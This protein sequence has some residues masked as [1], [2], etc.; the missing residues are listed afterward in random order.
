[1]SGARAD[2][3]RRLGVVV[4]A[5]V[6]CGAYLLGSLP[7]LDRRGVTAEEVQPTLKRYPRVLEWRGAAVVPMPPYEPG[8]PPDPR[9]VAT[10]QWPVVGWN[11]ASRVWPVLVRGH[12]SA[13]GAYPA[14]VLGDVL[15]GGLVGLRRTSAVLGLVMLLALFFAAV[16]LGAGPVG[17]AAAVGV[18]GAS[19]GFLFMSRSGFGFEVASRLGMMVAVALAARSEPPGV[20]RALAIGIVA[21][22]AIA[23]RA[24]IVA[25]LVPALAALLL[26]APRRLGFRTGAVL[27]ASAVA[28][29]LGLLAFVV[30]VTGIRQ[31]AAPL[32]GFPFAEIAVRI[33][34]APRQALL[35]LA[36]VGDAGAI[37]RPVREG[38]AGLND[39]SLFGAAA[40]GAVPVSIAIVRLRR[41]RATDAER[42]LV[43]GLAGSVVVGA[44]LYGPAPN[45]FQLGFG[46]EPLVAMAAGAQLAALPWR[47][48]SLVLWC[49]VAALRG[50]PTARLLATEGVA[51]NPMFSMAVQREAVRM[52]G[53]PGNDVLT[54]SYNHAGVLEALSGGRVQPVHAWPVLD[55]HG[56]GS[57]AENR[58]R[59]WRAIL[60]DLRPRRVL[61]VVG[62][63]MFEG[64]GMDGPAIAA[65]LHRV[66]AEQGLS[67]VPEAELLTESG[68]PGWALVRLEPFAAISSSPGSSSRHE[69]HP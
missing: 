34:S 35:Q 65:S 28:V 66:A 69:A 17:A 42:I 37:L 7:G 23:S 60:L 51:S 10:A 2:V 49:L 26:R 68:R 45:E 24:T 64:S 59:A 5:T 27:G 20:R 48:S 12:Q 46:L 41:G 19:A 4:L 50:G 22:L 33:V 11:G 6:G 54:T 8:A 53:A 36:W 58:D 13:L 63:N 15:G 61:L 56:P 16:R 29:P 57:P 1:M 32:A 55:G 44:W 52:V 62:T 38:A 18:L 21:G 40:L 31:E 9:W 43:A 67:I 14:I 47:R 25:A 39:V 3:R 30:L